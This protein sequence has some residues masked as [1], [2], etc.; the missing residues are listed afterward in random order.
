M[1]A[2]IENVLATLIAELDHLEADI[3]NPRRARERL[4]TIKK[5]V[6]TF[7]KTKHFGRDH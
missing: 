6:E 5:I 1:T 3:A 2:G 7:E 4:A